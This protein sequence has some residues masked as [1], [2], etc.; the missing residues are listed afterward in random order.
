MHEHFSLQL[1]TNTVIGVFT[2][3]DTPKQSTMLLIY[4]TKIRTNRFWFRMMKRASVRWRHSLWYWFL[5]ICQLFNWSSQ[6][7]I[8]KFMCYIFTHWTTITLSIT[9]CDK[10]FNVEHLSTTWK[11]VLF[12]MNIWDDIP[13]NNLFIKIEPSA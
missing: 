2:S 3:L 6:M 4:L 9:N 1:K 5:S 7:M 11:T 12:Y 8:T 13:N 10:M